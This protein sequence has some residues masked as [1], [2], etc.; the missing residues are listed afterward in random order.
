MQ[1][2]GCVRD[3]KRVIHFP[4]SPHKQMP[5]FKTTQCWGIADEQC[6]D[7]FRQTAKDSSHTYTRIYSPPSAA[8]FNLPLKEI[9]PFSEYSVDS[10]EYIVLHYG[11]KFNKVS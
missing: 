7:S 11:S 4:A 9:S 1:P 5:L 3:E 2:Q 8:V 6:C 10:F